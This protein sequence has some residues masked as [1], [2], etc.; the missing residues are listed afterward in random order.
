MTLIFFASPIR[1]QYKG[2]QKGTRSFLFVCPSAKREKRLVKGEK[3]E[4]YLPGWQGPG[5]KPGE[6]SF[7]GGAFTLDETRPTPFGG[8]GGR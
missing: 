1:E 4:G 3:E 6:T 2:K 5:P 8:A 7:S